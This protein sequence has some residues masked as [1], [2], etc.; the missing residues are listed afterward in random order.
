MHKQVMF[1][2]HCNVSGNRKIHVA[3]IAPLR[4]VSIAQGKMKGKKV[5]ICRSVS[6]R[7]AIFHAHSRVRA[8]WA[9][10]FVGIVFRTALVSLLSAGLS[11]GDGRAQLPRASSPLP[12]LKVAPG[13]YVHVGNIDMMKSANQGDA[14]NIGFIVGQ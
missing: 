1:V 14:A 9:L 7:R 13:V 11:A 4:E 10:H 12:V 2:L 6:C 3:S 8:A 5:A